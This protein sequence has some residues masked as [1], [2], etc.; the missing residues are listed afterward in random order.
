[1][2][3]LNAEN[4]RVKRQYLSF[5]KEAGRLSETSI[6]QVA[7]AIDRFTTYNRQRSFKVFHI[8]Q[9]IGFKKHLAEQTNPRTGEPLSKATLYSILT[10]LKNFFTWLADRPRFKSRIRY[11]DAEYFNLSEK[12]TRIAKTHREPRMPSLE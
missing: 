4:E 11:T 12:E 9:A 1:M 10:A 8:E 6:D 5:L 3:K 2:T 7:A